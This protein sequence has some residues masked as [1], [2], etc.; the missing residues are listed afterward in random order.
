MSIGLNLV[1]AVLVL[2]IQWTWS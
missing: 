1:G 2:F